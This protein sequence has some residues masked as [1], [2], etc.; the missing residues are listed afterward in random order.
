PCLRLSSRSLRPW[1]SQLRET[2]AFGSSTAT[3]IQLLRSAFPRL[4]CIQLTRGDRLRQ[5]ISKARA[6][7]TNRW[8]AGKEGHRKCE[9]V[10]DPE[11]I[12]HCLISAEISE[13]LWS[14][15]FQRNEIQPLAITYE[16]L[17][18]DYPG[19]VTR[20]LDFLCLRPPRDFILGPPQTQRQA[21]TLT[22][23]WLERYTRLARETS[24]THQATAP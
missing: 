12:N 16:D 8:V 22:D 5:A 7:Q 11:L 4:R 19:T 20:V 23:E 10:F 2:R 6:I 9:P 17:C 13:K 24:G 3:E 21:D 18:A 15:F 1:I 14:R